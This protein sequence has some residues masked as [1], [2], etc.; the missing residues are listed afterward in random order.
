MRQ[1]SRPL[2]CG[3]TARTAASAARVRRPRVA[4][5]RNPWFVAGDCEAVPRGERNMHRPAV[6][7]LTGR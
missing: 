1:A 6:Q 2:P 4:H 3:I 5:R 7:I